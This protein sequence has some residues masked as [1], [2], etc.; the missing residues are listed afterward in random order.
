MKIQIVGTRQRKTIICISL[1]DDL[2]HH[3]AG[4]FLPG[5]YDRTDS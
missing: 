5:I 1:T 4:F 3:G 2:G